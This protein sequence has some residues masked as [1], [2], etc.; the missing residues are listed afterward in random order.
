MQTAGQ[1]WIERQTRALVPP[2]R[3][4]LITF[5]LPA[6]LRPLALQQHERATP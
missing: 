4:F 6:Q 2:G 5:T 3:Y 1:R